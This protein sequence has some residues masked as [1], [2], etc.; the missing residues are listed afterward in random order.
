MALNYSTA[1]MFRHMR[2]VVY[3]SHAFTDKN[4]LKKNKSKQQMVTGL[5]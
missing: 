2:R 5:F 4:R 1:K 3:P